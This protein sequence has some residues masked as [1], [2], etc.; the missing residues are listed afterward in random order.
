MVSTKTASKG[1]EMTMCVLRNLFF[2]E[3]E[4]QMN[5][6]APRYPCGQRYYGMVSLFCLIFIGFAAHLFGAS[7]YRIQ[8]IGDSIT[9]GY[10][11]NPS[12][13][14]PFEFGYRSGLYT[15]LAAGGMAFQFVG[16]S[17]EPWNG[18]FGVPSNTPTLDLRTVSQDFCRG[19]GGMG[20]AYIATNIGAWITTDRPDII[21]LMVG[22]NDIGAGSSA[23]PTAAETNL[24]NIVSTIVTNLPNAYVLVAQITPYS[25]YTDAIVKYNNYIKNT[26]VPGFVTQGKRVSTVDQY[27][28]MLVPGTTA[29]DT[30]L[31][32]NGI[33]HPNAVVY[34]RMAQTW[35]TGMKA[36]SLPSVWS[37]V[38]VT[39]AAGSVMNLSSLAFTAGK[40]NQFG[41]PMSGVPV[42]TW[43]VTAGS[44]SITSLG[45]FTP[46][47]VGSATI[48]ASA[49]TD[50]G[51]RS[52]SL[53]VSVTSS[54]AGTGSSSSSS[55]HCGIGGGV[56]SL[57]IA[58]MAAACLILRVVRR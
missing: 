20:T 38:A 39:A 21:L 30:A 53:T 28:N 1:V 16:T 41:D 19:Y 4:A 43:A 49:T 31:F 57:M 24:S 58:T 37:G 25:S 26:L 13:T 54:S 44:G 35:L 3:A 46:T 33:N 45:I 56:A 11:N 8:P 6:R 5:A 48:T 27:A 32:S 55:G 29:I 12:W 34:D 40:L 2:R 15:R 10:T 22:I 36:L 17:A 9:V 14:V 50:A 7:S 18:T 52:R 47:A 42:V 23:E 51:V